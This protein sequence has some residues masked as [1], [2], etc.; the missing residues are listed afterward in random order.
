MIDNNPV[1]FLLTID[2]KI[3]YYQLILKKIKNNSIESYI[4]ENFLHNS[5]LLI[6]EIVNESF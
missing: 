1:T 6:V 4:A 2:K 3:I 5:W